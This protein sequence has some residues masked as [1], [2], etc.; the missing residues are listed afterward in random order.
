MS[1]SI[2]CL[3]LGLSVTLAT[4]ACSGG[5]G[6]SDS[7]ALRADRDGD[8]LPDVLEGELGSDPRDPDAPY[9]EGADDD[10]T[11][12]GPG[13]D[14][15]RDGLERYL[16]ARGA[17]AP[18]TAVS[19]T[20]GDQVP[21]YLEV[22]SHLDPFDFDVPLLNGS[23]DLA[24]PGG[25]AL[26]GISDAL[27]SYLL[28]RGAVAPLTASSDTDAD[29]LPDV[30]EARSGSDPFGASSPA[31][32]RA[33][34]LDHDDVPDWLEL[35]FH[36]DPLDAD[37]PT[38]DGDDDDDGGL[39]G[40]DGDGVKDGL[41]GWLLRAGALAPVT[42][43]DDS[44]GDGLWD[45]A[46]VRAGCDPFDADNPRVDGGADADGD[47]LSDALEHML[48]QKGARAATRASDSD[49]DFVPDFAELGA[50]SDPFDRATPVLFAH[51]DLDGDTL[52]DF[53][54]LVEGSDPLDAESPLA[55]G[56]RDI[57]DAT[58]PARD[59]ISDALEALL[60]ARGTSAPV[61]TYSDSDADGV[62]DFIELH[63][64]SDPFDGNSPLRNGGADDDDDS[65][66]GDDG[67]SDA[68]EFVLLGL[69]I[70][71]PLDATRNSDT[72]VIPDAIELLIGSNP[73]DAKSPHPSRNPDIDG[74]GVVD[75]L[76]L[77]LDFDP[78]SADVPVLAGGLDSDDD[79]LSDA[80]EE[81]LRLTSTPEPVT[82]LS[83]SDG[84][85]LYDHLEVRFASNRADPDHPLVAGGLDVNDRTGPAGDGMSDALEHFLVESGATRPV[86]TSNDTDGDV[87]PDYLEVRLAL[88][89]FDPTSPLANG[90]D[91][92]DGDG[93]SN[94]LEFVLVRLGASAPVDGRTDT[95]QD[96]APDHLELFAGADAFDGDVP[97]VNG[98]ADSDGDHLSDAL[99]GVLVALGAAAPIDSRTDTDEDGIAD[100]FEVLAGTHPLRGDH[101]LANGSLDVN[102]ASGPRDTIS[103]ALEAL[104]VDLG[105]SAPVTRANDTD[106]DGA[107][108]HLE[109]LAVAHPAQ[110]DEPV[111]NG[112]SDD[113]D[114]RLSAALEEVLARLGAE[115]P[116]DSG[117]DTDGDGAPDH[118]EVALAAHPVDGDVPI[119][120]GDGAAFDVDATTGTNG[121]GIS[122]AFESLLI[123]LGCQGPILTTGD[124]DL[125]GLPDYFEVRVG[126]RPLDADSPLAGGGVDTD[127]ASGPAGDGL[128]DALEALLIAHGALGPVTRS[129]DTDGD[130]V[131]DFFEVF[132][133]SD[134]FDALD[135]IPPGTR[136]RAFGLALD[137]IPLEGRP[138]GGTYRYTDDE[139]DPEGVSTFRWLRNG[140][141]IPG[142]TAQTYLLD[143]ADLGTTLTF[144]VTP[145]SAFAYPV[146][147]E[148]G[149][150]TTVARAIPLPNFP[151][152]GGGPGGVGTADGTSELRLW[153]RPDLGVERTGPDISTWRDQSGYGNHAV[154]V[155]TTRRPDLVEGAGLLGAPAVRFNGDAHLA[156]PRP[157]EDNLTYAAVFA[158]TS[159]ASSPNWFESPGLLGGEVPGGCGDFH[160]G[161][162]GGKPLFVAA[163]GQITTGNTF[164][165]G[166][167]H[168]M[169]VTR[170]LSNGR[171]RLYVDGPQRSSAISAP[172]LA[173]NCPTTIYLGSATDTVGF[174]SGDLLECVAYSK[175][176]SDSERAILDVYFAARYGSQPAE[177]LYDFLD[178]HR[179]DVA[180]IG[181]ES[182]ASVLTSA[183]GRGIVRI[184][185]PSALSDGDYLLWG[186]D[187]PDDYSLSTNVPPAFTQRLRRVFARTITDGGAGD[188][189]GLVSVRVRVGGLF[190]STD[191][192]DFA[193]LLDDDGDFS[194]AV[195]H[196][197]PGVYDLTVNAVEFNSVDLSRHRFFALVV[198]P[199]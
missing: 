76:E 179:G 43:L 181:R 193:L 26:D 138:F 97:V 117:S 156:V 74:D 130:G 93:V 82:P 57:D 55:G 95:D 183:E 104:L 144:E 153:L 107:P 11:L 111:A 198:Q 199:L 22:A 77:E 165:N 149:L 131:P 101:P 89:A 126:T 160:F 9:L 128:S 79:G 67:I 132:K 164:N 51:G 106:G 60:I 94:A 61:T 109:A 142:A 14:A 134:P 116:L 118:L 3:A 150:P 32:G 19:D 121:D 174:Y 39:L 180:G 27:E 78:R 113:D 2:R 125:D 143:A 105:A 80:L 103:D 98:A 155:R 159:T 157:V 195:V 16:L 185:Q 73:V 184:S 30:L 158:T 154:T 120:G 44:D 191:P 148:V 86:S 31:Y 137:G 81:T 38:F 140:V 36:S 146:E 7:L 99:E 102:D 171:N 168:S 65:G 45:V 53:L 167:P 90:Q 85:G 188:G 25:P 17:V 127:D 177:D 170:V 83:D 70:A 50:G 139:L 28:R 54:E 10:D 194:D 196:P 161:V 8:G 58:G 197:L 162:N 87:I 29:G 64:V 176:L 145:V 129:T 71:G 119:R 189:V 37:F 47:G 18:I 114:D 34:D 62:P 68:A 122:D 66:P 172:G 141:A 135:E 21:D 124:T 110:F 5:G 56:A 187:R 182:D 100:A 96:G 169:V 63:L 52:V 72:D 192:E 59:P 33:F 49:R 152:G 166:L 147:T 173:L 23:G 88:D 123:A 24:N 40:P 91:D 15:L 178:T 69:G 133:G 41:E 108:D 136:P 1:K 84:D 175:V 46:E 163:D 6:G 115:L 13:P 151:H 112:A 48:L 75:W 12:A 42:T 190:L 35:A 186:T 4:L 92:D 20:D